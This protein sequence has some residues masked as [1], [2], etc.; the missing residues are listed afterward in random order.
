MHESLSCACRLLTVILILHS[1]FLQVNT[2]NIKSDKSLLFLWI[3]AKLRGAS[4][5]ITHD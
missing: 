3:I 5:V 1:F 4:I 2:I